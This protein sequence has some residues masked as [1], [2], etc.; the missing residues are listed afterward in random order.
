MTVIKDQ[1]LQEEKSTVWL[2]FPEMFVEELFDTHRKE[3][4]ETTGLLCYEKKSYDMSI[5]NPYMNRKK[6][7]I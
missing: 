6:K 4:P 1:L 2:H 7:K 5:H 3:N